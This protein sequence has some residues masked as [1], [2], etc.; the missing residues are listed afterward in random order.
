MCFINSV[1]ILYVADAPADA[2][3]SICCKKP[4]SRQNFFQYHTTR[5]TNIVSIQN[6]INGGGVSLHVNFDGLHFGRIYSGSTRTQ[7]VSSHENPQLGWL[8]IIPFQAKNAI[9]S[10]FYIV[11]VKESSN[12]MTKFMILLIFHM[13]MFQFFL[14][15]PHNILIQI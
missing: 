7:S 8:K 4:S 2:V 12:T 9:K 15:I 6:V 1:I 11:K 10:K 3:T 5:A 14:L 13:K